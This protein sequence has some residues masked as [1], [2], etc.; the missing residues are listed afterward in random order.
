[1]KALRKQTIAVAA[2]LLTLAGAATAQVKDYREIKT[3]PLR[4]F[5]MPQP[6]RVQLANGM[7]IFLQEDHELPLIRGSAVIRGG[8]RDIPANK[9]GLLG[10]YT[11]AWRTGGTTSKSGEQLDELLEARAARVET[12]GD[13]DSTTVH[14]DML[15]GD[16]DSV[17]P[18]FVDVLRNPA[19]RQEKVDLARTQVNS[20]ISRRNDDPGTILQ[21]ESS[22]L[23]Y[24]SD[25]PY[26]RQAEYATVASITR[27]DL[28]ALHDRFVH[29]NDIILGVVGDF[30]SATMEATLRR[31]FDSWVRGPQTAKPDDAGHAAKAGTYFIAKDDVTQS[32]IAVVHPATLVRNSP[33]YFPAL[34]FNEI[35]SGGFSGR[36]MNR[37]R[38]ELGL[39]YGV[40]G[41]VGAGWDHPT[42]F[43]SSMSTKSSTTMQSVDALRT[44]LAATQTKPFTPDELSH[45]KES[46]LNAFVFTADSREKVLNQRM[47]LEFY[48]Y[49]A[50]FYQRYPANIQKV[51]AEDVASVAKKYIHPD[52][53][54]VLVL[55]NEKD[56][57]KP[58]SSLGEVT[59]LDITIPEPGAKAP[60]GGGGSAMSA[61]AAPATSNPEGMALAQK[62]RSFLGGAAT[63]DAVKTM[64]SHVT[65]NVQTPN[66]PMSMQVE[67]TTQY[68]DREQT[69]MKTP[70]GDMTIVATGE[71]GFM[72]TPGGP[73]DMPSSQREDA[74]RN[75]R[76]ELI[77]LFMT[78]PTATYH[79]A[80]H[81]KVGDIDAAILEIGAIRLWIDPATGRVLRKL[82]PERGGLVTEYSD[83]KKFGDLTLPAK[84]RA[85]R[86][87]EESG[88]G[89]IQSIDFNVP[90]DASIFKKP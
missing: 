80:G 44:E 12:N 63:L 61:P 56:F 57:E 60:A 82:S 20:A 35:L 45:A 90:V 77:P 42:L 41:G 83:W 14:F 21:R 2:G 29:P 23:G 7:V 89:E 46:L 71:N 67:K 17:F 87:G 48:G 47:M 1:M 84:F 9:A 19:F 64:R 18:I 38:T 15:K 28:V 6:K 75:M 36:L 37:L 50:D 58:L 3:P 72:L 59:R 74:L 33:D 51:T 39:T 53:F 79:A 5:T 34:V 68:P 31:T 10:I 70:M 65:M 55:G 52:Q 88:S 4:A 62:V 85:T 78:S 32:S 24:G 26:A 22:K 40:G 73:R 30:D 11:G 8:A 16:F 25:S 43:S 54:R 49:P 81:E 27:D 69:V 13:N 66:G 86:N 76:T